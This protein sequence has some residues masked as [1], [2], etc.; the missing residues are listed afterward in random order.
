[1]DLTIQCTR[2]S[3]IPLAP[4]NVTEYDALSGITN[5]YRR[6][7]ANPKMSDDDMTILEI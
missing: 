2:R 1:M 3:E 6:L 4:K 5:D 7:N